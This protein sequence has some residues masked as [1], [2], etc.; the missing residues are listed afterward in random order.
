MDTPLGVRVSGA[1]ETRH[2]LLTNCA[3]I[4]YPEYRWWNMSLGQWKP[5]P[6][7]LEKFLKLLKTNP[8]LFTFNRV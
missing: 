2:H 6:L 1:L 5:P 3:K 7:S 8:K 4:D